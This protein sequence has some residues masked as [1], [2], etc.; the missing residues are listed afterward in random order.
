MRKLLIIL[1]C[2]L[3]LFS[4]REDD[5]PLPNPEPQKIIF[6]GTLI[7]DQ[8][9]NNTHIRDTMFN[10]TLTNSVLGNDS[11][12]KVSI[13]MPELSS[14]ITAQFVVAVAFSDNNSKTITGAD[15]CI[16][17]Q[18]KQSTDGQSVEYRKTA[19]CEPGTDYFF[20]GTR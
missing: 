20:E 13:F 19:T 17:W 1:I 18:F 9:G 7:S 4:C 8:H 16:A 11:A 10:C 2:S 14:T 15:N 5:S 12:I 6:Y 3:I